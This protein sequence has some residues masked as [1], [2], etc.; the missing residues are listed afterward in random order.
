MSNDD[1]DVP[2]YGQQ[3]KMITEDLWIKGNIL[4]LT[5]EESNEQ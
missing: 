5:Q 4:E 1:L 3:T 2:P